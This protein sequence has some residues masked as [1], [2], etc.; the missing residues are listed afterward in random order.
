[1]A[2]AYRKKIPIMAL[3]TFVRMPG[4][5]QRQKQRWQHRDA[6]KG[7]RETVVKIEVTWYLW[8]LSDIM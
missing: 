1:M 5:Y 3:K 7:F 2:W 4:R 8:T 6:Q